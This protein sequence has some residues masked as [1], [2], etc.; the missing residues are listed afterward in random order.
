[1]KGKGLSSYDYVIKKLGWRQ[2]AHWNLWYMYKNNGLYKSWYGA[3]LRCLFVPEEVDVEP[4]FLVIKTNNRLWMQQTVERIHE[5]GFMPKYNDW[6][7]HSQINHNKE[8][9]V[10]PVWENSPE[11]VII[12]HLRSIHILS[13]IIYCICFFVFCFEHVL[14]Y[15]QMS[16]QEKLRFMHKFKKRVKNIFSQIMRCL[17]SELAIYLFLNL[18]RITMSKWFSFGAH[19]TYSVNNPHFQ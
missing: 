7:F 10:E 11:A 17:Y 6:A 14:K 5:A 1:M 16:D 15:N 12:K 4:W 9:F 3:S 13:G 2:P 18:L 8:R 19:K